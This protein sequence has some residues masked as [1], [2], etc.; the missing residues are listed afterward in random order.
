MGFILHLMQVY[1]GAWA[2]IETVIENQ[3]C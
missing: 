1:L 3:V 2:K